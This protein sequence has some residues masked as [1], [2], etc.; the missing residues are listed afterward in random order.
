MQNKVEKQNILFGYRWFHY[1]HK[2][3]IHRDIAEDI[4]IRFH[5]SNYELDHCLKEK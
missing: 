1:I 2:N 3:N 5:T 4:E